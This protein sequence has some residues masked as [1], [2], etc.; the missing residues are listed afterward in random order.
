MLY[1]RNADGRRQSLTEHSRAVAKVSSSRCADIGLSALAM[2][3]ALLHDY[4]KS[5]QRFQ[6]Y[7]LNGA[8]RV[9]HAPYSVEFV[10]RIFNDEK[11]TCAQLTTQILCL[12]I[13]GHHG[14]LHDAL[15]PSGDLDEPLPSEYSGEEILEAQQRFFKE[16]ASLAELR[17]LFERAR[18]EVEA[19]FRAVLGLTKKQPISDDNE[20]SKNEA[21]FYMGLATRFVY[22]ALIDAD[23]LDAATWENGEAPPEDL[24]PNWEDMQTKLEEYLKHFDKNG[25][26]RLRAEISDKCGEFDAQNGIYRLFVPTGGGKNLSAFRA[27]LGAAKRHGKRR[28]L[29]AAPFLAVLEQNAKEI[30]AAIGEAEADDSETAESAV[31]EFHSN[32]IFDDDDKGEEQEKRFSKLSERLDAPIVFTSFVQLLNALYSGKGASARRFSALSNSVIIIDEVQ[33]VPLNSTYLFDLGINFL[34]RFCNCPVILCTATPPALE[35]IKYPVR[36]SQKPDI[37]ENSPELFEAFKRTRIIS[38]PGSRFDT[39]ALSDF[40]L[41]KLRENQSCLVIVNTKAAAKKLYQAACEKANSEIRVFYLS[42]ELCPAHRSERIRHIKKLLGG[43][44]AGENGFG[45]EK[46]L[47]ISTQL[48]EAGVNISFDCV[49]R[50]FAGL[51]SIIQAAGRCNRH[52]RHSCG[53]VYVVD[54]T[55]ERLDMLPDIKRGKGISLVMAAAF[56]EEDL[57][58]PQMI[59]R[60]YVQMFDD[61]KGALDYPVC[62][63]AAL[64]LLGNNKTARDEYQAQNN[65]KFPTDLLASA[66]RSV[67]KEYLPI[68]DNTTGVVVPYGEAAELVKKLK[69]AKGA[70]KRRYYRSLQKYT[71]NLFENKLEL[72]KSSGAVSFDEETGLWLL[73]EGFYDE[74]CGI[75]MPGK[76]SVDLYII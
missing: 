40:A 69:A 62:K 33:A 53:C 38:Y 24:T 22:S 63:R 74:N 75:I 44:E 72:L 35:G 25:I 61:S 50:S 51:D 7:L 23:R 64:E 66:F 56:G 1:A 55:D 19:L 70:K 36:M 14:G 12:V 39:A 18:Q 41:E 5:Y 71:V 6:E 30:R 76:E 8:Q 20:T 34:S 59:N 65:K 31:L 52:A 68:A 10:K 54:Y 15:T 43:E 67:G 46:L 2:L 17:E 9:F 28:I 21:M 4:G 58:S 37:I 45:N 73:A 42:T 48:I 49:V 13:R 57:S 47:V 11:G 16:V 60:Y 32:I 29:Y 27:A 26:G 3:A